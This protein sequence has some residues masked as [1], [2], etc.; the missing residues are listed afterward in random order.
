MH[1]IVLALA[2]SI[3]AIAAFTAMSFIFADA[4]RSRTGFI[5]V[6]C[7]IAVVLFLM[8]GV[9]RNI[10]TDHISPLGIFDEH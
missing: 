5:V 1:N 6:G 9:E 4:K 3:G 7:V 2:A 8:I 10:R